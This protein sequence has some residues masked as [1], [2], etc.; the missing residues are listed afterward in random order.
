MNSKHSSTISDALHQPCP[1]LYEAIIQE[2]EGDIRKHI[3][4]QQQ[5]KLH[6]ESVED[7]V[8]ELEFELVDFEKKLEN[9]DKAI[10]SLTVDL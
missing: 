5:L 9:K 8:E 2:L 7:R 3:R 10:E 6:I 4:I 1:P